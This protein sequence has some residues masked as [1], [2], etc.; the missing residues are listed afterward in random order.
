V[1]SEFLIQGGAEL[2][3]EAWWIRALWDLNQKY[4]AWKKMRGPVGSPKSW[5]LT[6]D[7]VRWMLVNP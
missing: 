2:W 6:A 1:S 5:A 3:V 7:L 4:R